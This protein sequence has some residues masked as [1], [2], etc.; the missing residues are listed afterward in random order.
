[1]GSAM[2]VTAIARA[3]AAGLTRILGAKLYGVYLYGAAAFPDV[4]PTGD[5]D[6]H[7]ILRAPL[8]APERVELEALH[9]ALAAQYPPLGGELD[10]Y[11]VLLSDAQGTQPPRSE[12]WAHAVDESWALHRAHIR[13]GR[14]IVLYGPD[15]STI[16]P[17]ATWPEIE[18]ALRS[19][20]AFVVRNLEQ[21]PA[22]C[23]LNLCRLIYSYQTRDVVVSKAFAA[24]W[25]E[26]ALP[27]WRGLV[28]AACRFYAGEA[29]LEDERLMRAELPGLLAEA[30]DTIARCAL[31][32]PSSDA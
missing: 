14:C 10:G 11:Y 31:D 19:E 25:A 8:S 9:R 1:M 3:F 27:E 4:F 21:Y 5:I 18:R 13:A 20:W 6:Y 30:R 32:T 2:E 12:M 7:V 26:A 24:R 28:A 17:P 16:Y 29:T 15:P 23:I 22:Y